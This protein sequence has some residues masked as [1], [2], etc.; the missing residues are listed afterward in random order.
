MLEPVLQGYA[1][2]GSTQFYITFAASS[3]EYSSPEDD[4]E[5]EDESG[6]DP[7]G[8][9]IDECFLASSILHS[10]PNM[11]PLS[12]R[13]TVTD[14]LRDTNVEPG[15]PTTSHVEFRFFTEPLPVP[16]SASQDDCTLYLRTSD[17]GRIGI[18]NGDWVNYF[19]V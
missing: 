13:E 14:R 10:R 17:L 19:F 11:T 2:K 16:A 9:E 15:E 8:I 7:D 5:V 1:R 6:S 3:N 12:P 18:L 4:V